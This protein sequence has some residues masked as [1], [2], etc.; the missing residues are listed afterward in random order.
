[1]K[2]TSISG[3]VEKIELSTHSN[4]QCG[5]N[6]A[7]IELVQDST[8]CKTKDAGEFDKGTTLEWTASTL[9]TCVGKDFDVLNDEIKFKTMSNDGNDYCPKT[10]TITMNNGDEYKKEGMNINSWIDNRRG[11][12]YQLIQIAKRK[13]SM[14][15]L[16][17]E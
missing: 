6:S 9:D 2:F 8:S 12:K 17:S 5:G 13:Y 3:K 7:Y 11:Q 16:K 14:L 10:L 15:S 1:M 4:S